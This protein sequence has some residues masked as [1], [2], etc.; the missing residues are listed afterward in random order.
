[1]AKSRKRLDGVGPLS[2]EQKRERDA[3]AQKWM[4]NRKIERV[5]EAAERAHRYEF[6]VEY[7]EALINVDNSYRFDD[8]GFM[9]L[10]TD[11]GEYRVYGLGENRAMYFVRK[12]L[13][14]VA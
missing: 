5:A 14:Y 13:S 8:D 12:I 9:I 2:K 6:P 10:I 11:A 1:M 3:R 7:V 4:N